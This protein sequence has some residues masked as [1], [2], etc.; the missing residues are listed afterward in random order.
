MSDPIRQRTSEHRWE[1]RVLFGPAD[2]VAAEALTQEIAEQLS[3]WLVP[4]VS[5]HLW[6]EAAVELSSQQIAQVRE[7]LFDAWEIIALAK[8]MDSEKARS[9]LALLDGETS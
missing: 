7:T 1:V 9:V 4:V 3:G 2:R 5:L 8:K 6:D